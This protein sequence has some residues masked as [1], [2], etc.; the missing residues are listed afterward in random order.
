MKRTIP[1]YLTALIVFGLG[2]FFAIKHGQRLPAPQAGNGA[3][4]AS[5][6]RLPGE[7]KPR[8]VW[9]AM[10][11]NMKDPLSRLLLQV[12]VIIIATRTVGATAA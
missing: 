7:S 11:E 2:L 10:G 8:S 4:V 3:A 1:I 9:S 12:I 5:D 6:S